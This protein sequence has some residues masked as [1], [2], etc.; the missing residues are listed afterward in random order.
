MKLSIC[1]S[2]TTESA[3]AAVSTGQGFVQYTIY[4]NCRNAGSYIS[5]F[6]E[7]DINVLLDSNICVFPLC[8]QTV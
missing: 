1:E 4:L 3:L 5:V 7:E 6:P 2:R 8:S